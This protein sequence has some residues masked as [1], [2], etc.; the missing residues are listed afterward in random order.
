MSAWTKQKFDAIPVGYTVKVKKSND[1]NVLRVANKIESFG[2]LMDAGFFNKSYSVLDKITCG[3]NMYFRLM[4]SEEMMDFLCLDSE[5]VDELPAI[6]VEAIDPVS[7]REVQD[8]KRKNKE[9]VEKHTKGLGI[10]PIKIG[11]LGIEVLKNSQSFSFN[12]TV[13]KTVSYE[14]LASCRD[15]AVES[16][17]EILTDSN[18]NNFKLL[19]AYSESMKEK[20]YIKNIILF[21][22][23]IEGKLGFRKSKFFNVNGTSNVYAAKPSTEWTSCSFLFSLYMLI[24]RTGM[25]VDHKHSVEKII[26][27][28]K[29]GKDKFLSLYLKQHRDGKLMSDGTYESQQQFNEISDAL[30]FM[31]EKKVKNI[32]TLKFNQTLWWNRKGIVD[33]VVHGRDIPVNFLNPRIRKSVVSNY[34]KSTSYHDKGD[35]V[36]KFNNIIGAMK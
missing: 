36:V 10:K 32:F 17:S 9:K 22:Q 6:P 30:L 12:P 18:K 2:D 25:V 14:S 28:M 21:T 11:G 27:E 31:M 16:A 13:G 7:L 33:H 20:N 8:I 1:K 15:I 34:C 29:K 35:N 4:L 19:F 5:D 23:K 26:R 3:K 24:I